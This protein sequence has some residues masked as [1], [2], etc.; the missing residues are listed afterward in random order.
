MNLKL[1]HFLAVGFMFFTVVGTLSHEFGHFAVARFLGYS[2]KISYGSTYNSDANIRAQHDTIMKKYEREYKADLSY[3]GKEQ[4]ELEVSKFKANHIFIILGGPVQTL[5]T[6]IIA[7]IFILINIDVFKGQKD[8][9][10]SKWLLVFLALF[11][12]RQPANF[13]TGI[14]GYF[15]TGRFSNANDEAKIDFLLALP[16]F[17]SSIITNLLSLSIFAFIFFKVIPKPVRITF[18]AAGLVGGVLGFYLWFY[19]MGPVVMPV[20]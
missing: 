19:V 5:L 17:T 4:F 7:F 13:F 16:P 2:A 1:F 15:I 14:I 9:S 12:L 3:P 10:F 8:L 20:N 6:S 11:S 18:A